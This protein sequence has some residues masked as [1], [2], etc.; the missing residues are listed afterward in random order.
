MMKE[1]SST[2]FILLLDGGSASRGRVR[3]WLTDCG[4]ITWEARDVGHAIEEVSDFTVKTRPDVVLLEVPTMPECFDTFR[5][6]FPVPPEG[7]QL[8]VLALSK[9]ESRREIKPYVANSLA[10]LRT[11]MSRGHDQSTQAV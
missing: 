2:T 3:R 7:N 5:S 6:T 1:S 8:S 9:N 10:Q 11:I 4:F